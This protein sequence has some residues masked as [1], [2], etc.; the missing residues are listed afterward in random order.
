MQDML[1]PCVRIPGRENSEVKGCLLLVHMRATYR[2]AASTSDFP[3]V[4][5]L[6]GLRP[7]ITEASFKVLSEWNASEKYTEMHTIGLYP[8]PVLVDRFYRKE[9]I[10]AWDFKEC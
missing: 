8:Y 5:P 10:I 7:P 4:F 6:D 1:I 9:E 2:Q 3:K